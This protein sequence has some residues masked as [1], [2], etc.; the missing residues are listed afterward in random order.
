MTERL[1]EAHGRSL[2]STTA[3]HNNYRWKK[4]ASTQLT[5]AGVQHH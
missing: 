1:S 5:V 3:M 4:H 2:W